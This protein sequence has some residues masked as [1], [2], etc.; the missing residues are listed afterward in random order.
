MSAKLYFMR[1]SLGIGP[2]TD[3]ATHAAKDY[4]GQRDDL[5]SVAIRTVSIGGSWRRCLLAV[6]AGSLILSF[7][8]DHRMVNGK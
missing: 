2:F 8:G 6:D 5:E 4:F 3:S 7:I 1:I